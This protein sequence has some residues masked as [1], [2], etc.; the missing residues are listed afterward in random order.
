MHKKSD[1][2]VDIEQHETFLEEC[3]EFDYNY[4]NKN[5]SEYNSDLYLFDMYSGIC[6]TSIF[7]PESKESPRV[8]IDFGYYAGPYQH[9]QNG[10]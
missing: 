4:K 7:F 1:N 3:I 8:V 9:Q 10:I 5:H 2:Y 6:G